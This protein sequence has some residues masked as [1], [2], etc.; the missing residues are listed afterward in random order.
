MALTK[1][2][3]NLDATVATTQ[4]AS[5]N[6]T[7][8]ATTAY[9][10]TA[11]NNLIDG[12]PSTLNTLDEIA[13]ALNDDAALNTTLTNSIATKLPLAGGTM[14]GALIVDAGNSG[15]DV[16]VGTDKRVLWQG[17][18]GEIG[19]VAGFQAVNTAGS[20]NTDFGIRAT[21]IRLATGSSEKVRVAA[22][23]HLEFNPVNSFAALNNSILSSS[24]TY[25][26][27]MG[28]AAGL[29]LANN[30][31][32]D[33]SIGI[34]DANY[35]DFNTSSGE[36]MRLTSAGNVG[37]GTTTPNQWA[38]YTDSSATVLQVED[39]SQRA[40]MVINGNFP[41]LDLV[42][43]AG[44]SDDKHLN[45]LLVNGY[46][47]FGSLTDNGSAWVQQYILGM[48]LGTGNVGIGYASPSAANKLQ[49]DGKGYFGP[50]GTGQ[51]D[52]KANMGTN[53]VL[54]LKPHDSNSTN[55]TFAQVNGGNG[56]GIQVSNSSQTANWEIALNPYGGNVGIGTPDPAYAL[57][58]KRTVTSD[59]LSRIYNTGTSAD[60]GGLLVRTDSG[61]NS[62]ITLGVYS[63]GSYKLSVLGDGKVGVGTHAPDTNFHVK[64]TGSIELRLEADS[65]NAG[66][67][68]C[69][70]RF[71]TD[72]K[73]QEGIAGM[74]NNNSST[75]FS[76]NT[77][78]A[79]VFGTVSNLPTVFATNNTERVRIKDSGEMVIG[80]PSANAVSNSKLTVDGGDM[81]VQAAYN[82]IGMSDLL[83][84]YTRGH[85]G[86]IRSSANYVY[87]VIGSSYVSNINT[88]GTYGASDLRLKTNVSTIT[89]ALDKVKQLRG[90][91][92]KWNEEER[93]TGNNLGFIAQ[94]METVLPELVNEAG[95]PN[96]EKGEAPIKSVNYANLTSVLVEAIKELEARVKELEG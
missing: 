91:N 92:F 76:G 68:D 17:N 72:G 5:D 33:T 74:D 71:Y 55:M 48:D 83:P 54:Q 8:V 12:A 52:S 90:V 56:I 13:A 14:T 37:I 2:P 25:M 30:S 96:N 64:D 53:A 10:T 27:M 80:G 63:G 89:G 19:S 58:V 4:S 79:M 94:E 42:N 38:S 32:L 93:G 65:N 78:N 41:N 85:Y 18:I 82:N 34:R 66:Q 20:A 21:T 44:G 51:G 23:G 16:R 11:I 46:A 47:K 87:F 77:E 7:N 50:V 39:T 49:V 88:S 73:T 60:D 59:W 62:T 9:V 1:V 61:H 36:K 86:A 43:S 45:L 15:L 22:A 70:I 35:I 69:F 28:G 29:Y 24:N 84:G 75:L 67:E 95:L 81:M 57:E 6:S 40:R 31:G 3:S 26:Y